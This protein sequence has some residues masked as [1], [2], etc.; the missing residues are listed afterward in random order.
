MDVLDRHAEW[1]DLVADAVG[2]R[3][4][5]VCGMVLQRCGARRAA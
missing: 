3:V 2:L 5:V 4:G 1:A